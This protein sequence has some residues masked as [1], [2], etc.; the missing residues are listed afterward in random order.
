M[1]EG[2]FGSKGE[3]IFEIY[4]IADDGLI[5]ADAG[6]VLSLQV[7]RDFILKHLKQKVGLNAHNLISVN[8]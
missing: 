7:T 8:A 2:Q 5:I 4:L 3:L 6:V 1:I